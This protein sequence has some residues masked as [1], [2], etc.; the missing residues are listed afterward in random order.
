MGLATIFSLFVIAIVGV[1]ARV[2]ADCPRD[3]LYQS[4]SYDGPALCSGILKAGCTHVPLPTH[5]SQYP[6]EKI[7]SYVSYHHQI[8][9]YWD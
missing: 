4:L 8:V 5:Y 2:P 9:W 7:S 1:G 6:Q 3:A